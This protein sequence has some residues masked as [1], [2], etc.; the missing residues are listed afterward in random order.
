LSSQQCICLLIVI[1]GGIK[2]TSIRCNILVLKCLKEG[3]CDVRVGEGG[4]LMTNES[5]ICPE[6]MEGTGWIMQKGFQLN[7]IVKLT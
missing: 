3:L 5:N 2:Y 1:D 4:V 6:N 7:S